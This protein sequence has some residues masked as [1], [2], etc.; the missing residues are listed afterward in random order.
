MRSTGWMFVFVFQWL[1][2]SHRKVRKSFSDAFRKTDPW[3]FERQEEKER[4]QYSLELLDR[5]RPDAK[6]STALEIGCAEGVF[7]EQLAT[8]CDRL[9][10]IDFVPTAIERARQR[11]QSH[12]EV[13][14]DC[15]DFETDPLGTFDLVVAMMVVDSTSPIEVRR[16]RDRVVS[17]VRPGGFLLLNNYRISEFLER[18]AWSRW[19]LQGG[20]QVNDA[21][22]RHPQ[23]EEM[24]SI[25]TK[26]AVCTLYRRKEM[27]LEPLEH[28]PEPKPAVTA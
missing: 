15:L 5:V 19:L 28:H 14:F 26:L 4:F 6:F 12:P 22:A 13:Q 25:T 2:D 27:V 18:T 24:R 21:Y 1:S 8:R 20:K 17:L 7:T 16:R 10:A 3:D 23:L 9:L 11:L